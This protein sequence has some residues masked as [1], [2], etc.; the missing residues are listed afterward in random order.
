MQKYTCPCCGYKTID[1]EETFYDLCPVC[2]WET[3]PYQLAHPHYAGGANRPSL[4]E[5]QQNF[6]LFG[7]CEKDDVTKTRMPLVS[8]FQT[9][10]E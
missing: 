1:R 8:F 5:A 4:A 9:I 6:I 2:F 7:A 10:L 3:D